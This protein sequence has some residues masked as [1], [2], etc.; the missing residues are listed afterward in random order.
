MS[1]IEISDITKTYPGAGKPC[2]KE[3]S[4]PVEKGQIVALLGASGC[5]KTTLL[6]LISGLETADTGSILIDGESM[7][8]ISA[9]KRPVSMVFQKALLFANMNVEQN[10][11][12]APRVNKTMSRAQLKEETEKMLSLVQLDGMGKKRAT[13][14]SGGQEQRVSLARALMTRPKVLLLDE[15]LSALDAGLKQSMESMMRRINRSLD[16]TMLYVTHDQA[17]AAAVADMIALMHDGRIVQYAP[18]QEFYRRPADLYTASFFGWKNFIP[19][20]KEGELFSCSLGKPEVP[21]TGLADGA[22]MLCIRPEAACNIGTGPYTGTV[23]DIIPQG[24]D[25]LCTIRCGENTLSLLVRTAQ[26]LS[27]GDVLRFDLDQSLIW[28]VAAP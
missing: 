23:E 19:A 13:Q 14:L 26:S 6:K 12:F 28:A 18:P 27:S 5:G 24:P 11:N 20:F 17:E 15:P 9:E 8:G 4:L 10:V 2:L 22:V 21:G 7:A 3:L 25:R 1:Y 16:I